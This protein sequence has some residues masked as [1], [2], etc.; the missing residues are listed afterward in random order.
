MEP[1]EQLRRL[2]SGDGYLVVPGA[3]DALTARLVEVAG[4]EALYLTGGGFSRASGYPDMGLMT[5]L[6]VTHWVG[7]IGRAHV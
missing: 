7:Q 1:R 5:M 4:F 2:I 6:E 3:F